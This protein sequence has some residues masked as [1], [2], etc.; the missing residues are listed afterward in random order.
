M[1]YLR[2]RLKPL[3]YKA[4]KRLFSHR[5]YTFSP[6]IS[7]ILLVLIPLSLR[8]FEESAAISSRNYFFKKEGFF[9]TFVVL[10]LRCRK[11]EKD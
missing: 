9:E 2:Y 10:A 5:F 7:K 4:F 8:T 6:F 11:T 1:A 3:L